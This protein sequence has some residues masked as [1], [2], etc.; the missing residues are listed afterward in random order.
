MKLDE[1]I[2]V[3]KEDTEHPTARFL[4]DLLKAEQL[5][6]EALERIRAI[7]KG[8]IYNEMLAGDKLPNETDGKQ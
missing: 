1:A 3:L 7:R 8:L 5:G 6:I 2:K 4:P